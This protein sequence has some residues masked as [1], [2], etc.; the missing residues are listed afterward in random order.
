M[1]LAI[2]LIIDAVGLMIATAVLTYFFFRDLY[3]EIITQDKS[4]K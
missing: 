2:L 3:K 4:Q 1:D